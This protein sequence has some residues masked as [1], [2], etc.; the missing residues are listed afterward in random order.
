MDTS[1]PDVL[2]RMQVAH[3]EKEK[4]DLNERLR[5]VSKRVDHVERAFRKEE[6]PLLAEDYEQQQA[7]DRESFEANAKAILA[8]SKEKH[9]TDMATKKRLLRMMDDYRARHDVMTDKRNE[10]FK[11][12]KLAAQKKI[13]DEK[14]K[15]LATVLKVMEEERMMKEAEERRIKEA[16]E[17]ARLR[18]EGGILHTC[19]SVC[20]TDLYSFQSS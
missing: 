6:R 12:R 10:E 9:A 18:E 15:R 17:M 13:D 20:T 1:D 4:R 3:L 11:K 19:K 7:D 2:I 16:E 5:I 8:A 14:A